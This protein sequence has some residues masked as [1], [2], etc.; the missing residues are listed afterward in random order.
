MT[1]LFNL[2]NMTILVTGGS[3]GIGLGIAKICADHGASIILVGRNEERLKESQLL[4]KGAG[5]HCYYPLDLTSD[6]ALDILVDKLPILDGL[7]LN[8]GMVKIVPINY[9]KRTDLE[10]IFNLTLH[11]S[12]FLIQKLLKYKRI[13]N[14]SAIC[15]ISSVAS[16]K[17]SI[18]NAIYSSAKG[19]LN[20]FTKSLALELAPK[21]IR[22]N[23]VLPGLV[24][25]NILNSGPIESEQLV[26]HLKKYPLGRYGKPEDIGGLVLYLMSDISSWMTGSLLT[27]D[28]GYSLK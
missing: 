14:G 6:E 21:Q 18:G 20:S 24:E 25:T 26:E 3:S 4:L 10:Y 8:A 15:F 9:I 27:I 13:K 22:V 28:G 2:T 12:I 7:V 23:A 5:Q 19:A 11:S 1:D 17:V 16:Q